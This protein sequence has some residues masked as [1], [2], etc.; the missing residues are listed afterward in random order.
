MK[1]YLRLI[2][3]LLL[4]CQ[5]PCQADS[6]ATDS[7]SIRQYNLLL[8]VRGNDLSGICVMKMVSPTEMVGTVINEFGLTAFDFEYKEGKTRLSNLP[9][10]LDKWYIRKILRKD[11]SF[12]FANFLLQQN[13]KKR[14][15]ELIFSPDG[16]IILT[17]D[18]F[19]IKYTF[20]PIIDKE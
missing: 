20:T 15:R 17:N 4:F 14:S 2:S 6:I 12:F 13:T 7:A 10:F 3:L 19:K 18:R 11:L 9:P 5:L 8:Q 1:A 16:E